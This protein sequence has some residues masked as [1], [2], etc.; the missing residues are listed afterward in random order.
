MTFLACRHC[1]KTLYR[2]VRD[3]RCKQQCSGDDLSFHKPHRLQ[4]KICR[5]RSRN[6][7]EKTA[8]YS[9]SFFFYLWS[10]TAC[11]VT[12]SFSLVTSYFFSQIPFCISF[13]LPSVDLSFK[14]YF[15]LFRLFFSD[16]FISSVPIS[17]GKRKT[18]CLEYRHSRH[19]HRVTVLYSCGAMH[20][21]LL[22]DLAGRW[23][24]TCPSPLEC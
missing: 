19:T 18:K 11:I 15:F 9:F 3:A 17:F 16:L 5:G 22:V 6:L 7:Q 14:C 2:T 10:V 23:M 4:A 1:P 12:H 20:F 24:D 13:E 8:Y 21:L